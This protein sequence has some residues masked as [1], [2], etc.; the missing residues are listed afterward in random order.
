MAINTTPAS[1]DRDRIKSLVASGHIQEIQNAMEL[2]HFRRKQRKVAEVD[3][4]SHRIHIVAT[5]D[6]VDRD[7]E[8]ILPRSLEKDIAYYKDNP[9]VL[10]G[11]DHRIPAVGK[12]TDYAFSDEQMTMEIEFAVDANPLAKLLWGLYSEGYMRMSSIGFIP[13]EW[14]DDKEQKMEGQQGLTFLRNELIELSLVNVGSNRYALSDL[15]ALIKGD[16][17]MR[18]LYAN[19]VE[20]PHALE[21]EGETEIAVSQEKSLIHIPET[22]EGLPITIHLNVGGRS[23][24]EEPTTTKPEDTSKTMAQ[25]DKHKCPKCEASEAGQ[26]AATD[27]KQPR[28]LR[29]LNKHIGDGKARDAHIKEMAAEALIT[30]DEVEQILNGE[31][32]LPDA[33][34]IQAFAK[35]LQIENDLLLKAAASD[36]V[37]DEASDDKA[38]ESDVSDEDETDEEFED[39]DAESKESDDYKSKFYGM[40]GQSF[41]GSYEA[42]QAAIRQ[43]LEDFLEYK[44]GA[45]EYGYVDFSVLATYDDHVIVREWDDGNNYKATYTIDAEGEVEFTDLVE[46]RIVTTYEEIE[47][48]D[49]DD[50]PMAAD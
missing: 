45:N 26:G 21:I 10:F 9:V 46:V 38:T 43:D 15:S 6:T 37:S 49:A 22:K 44:V 28:L 16:P 35:A 24:D 4:E 48:E 30:T 8:R 36:E 42:R 33:F 25:Q 40:V 27:E 41:E 13:L 5:T 23:E 19:L 17:L 39:A 14:T 7:S 50:V 31:D 2:G 29:L 18:D 32:A 47:D 1:L 12:M 3:T 11:H 34:E 20:A